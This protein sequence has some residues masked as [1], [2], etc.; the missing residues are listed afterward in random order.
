MTEQPLVD[1]LSKI[2][3]KF[4]RSSLRPVLREHCRFLWKQVFGC[5]LAP[6]L[7]AARRCAQNRRYVATSPE[8]A[9]SQVLTSFVEQVQANAGPRF[10]DNDAAILQMLIHRVECAL[11]SAARRAARRREEP[12]PGPDCLHARGPTPADEVETR[13]FLAFLVRIVHDAYEEDCAACFCLKSN[14]LTV[15]QIAKD[16]ALS[17]STV[18]RY[19][20]A[21]RNV[22]RGYLGQD[23]PSD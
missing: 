7:R 21:A 23:E 10:P 14:G 9:V 18:S 16:R 8:D 13:D 4:A 20:A 2:R 11:N 22:V 12:L 19:L 6:L 5:L 3:S 17:R 1:L 15:R